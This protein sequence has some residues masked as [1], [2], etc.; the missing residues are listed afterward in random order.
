M[1]RNEVGGFGGIAPL[2]PTLFPGVSD[3]PRVPVGLLTRK[4][5]PVPVNF[6]DCWGCGGEG[7]GGGGVEREERGAQS[8]VACFEEQKY[9]LLSSV[10]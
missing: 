4:E 8:Q 10:K 5:P 3:H 6:D 7:G 2:M 9:L 1:K